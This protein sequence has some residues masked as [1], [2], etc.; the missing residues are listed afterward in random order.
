VSVRRL[1]V[2]ASAV[3]AVAIAAA[4][5]R[6][7]ETPRPQFSDREFWDLTSRLSEP[8]G[9]FKHS[10]NLVSNEDFFV[11]TLRVLEPRRGV[12]I[13]VG[14]EQ[15]FSYIARLQPDLAF[16]VDIRVR[17]RNLHLMYKALFESS[18][19]RV[20]F[21]SRL[22]SRQ[23]PSDVDTPASVHE[24]FTALAAT[25]SSSALRDDTTRIVRD[26]LLA[27]HAL[28]LSSDDLASID[29]TLAAF[30]EDGPAIHYGRS[31]PPTAAGPSY[32]TLMTA[33][34]IWGE[35]RSY[36]A[37]D[38]AFAVV[39]DLHSRNLIVPVVG[40]FAGDAAIRRIGEFVRGRGQVVSLFYASNVE[41][42]LTNQ[43]MVAYCG[44]LAGLPH[45]DDTR[46][47]GGKRTLALAEKL[48]QC[49]RRR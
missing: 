14:P 27:T 16:I 12:Y 45:D 43:Q 6:S 22:F 49:P 46:F 42:Y 25:K 29:A 39:K 35:P 7:E 20:E 30:Y 9:E 17:N 1:F 4:A 19:N 2:L 34:D 23:L 24:L 13:G 26:R 8:E 18:S 40:D 28:P 5:C 3:A 48:Q 11:H 36:L 32:E 10:E 15:N 44:N 21:A 37:S 47:V 38:D 33:K 41:R 31:L